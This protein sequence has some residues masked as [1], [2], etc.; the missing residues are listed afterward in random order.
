MSE[1][2]DGCDTIAVP[3]HLFWDPA[4]RCTTLGKILG[5]S[6][7]LDGETCSKGKVLEILGASSALDRILQVLF[8]FFSLTFV[9]MKGITFQETS[10][11]P[12]H[13]GLEKVCY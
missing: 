1:E 11:S 13:K 2:S 12:T 4:S 9:S 10:L 8:T 6:G 7:T 5:R 3:G